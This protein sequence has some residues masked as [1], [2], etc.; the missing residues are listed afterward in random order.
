MKV[1]GSITHINGLIS[2]PVSNLEANSIRPTWSV[3]IPTP[4]IDITTITFE[5][6]VTFFLFIISKMNIVELLQGRV[7]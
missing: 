5:S 6:V 7:G 1:E 4:Q 2:A 3:V